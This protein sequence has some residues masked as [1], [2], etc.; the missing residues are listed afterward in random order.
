MKVI[1]R[2]VNVRHTFCELH[3]TIS[4]RFDL[5]KSLP[6]ELIRLLGIWYLLIFFSLKDIILCAKV[7][8]AALIAAR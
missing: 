7:L 2:N 4:W 1:I 8:A 5:Q 3:G 6:F